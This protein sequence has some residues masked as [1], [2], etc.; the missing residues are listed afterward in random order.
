MMASSVIDWNAASE[1]GPVRVA[2]NTNISIA[3]PSAVIKSAVDS[4][5]AQRQFDVGSLPTLEE[6]LKS[7]PDRVSGDLGWEILK[8]LP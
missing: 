2:Q 6:H 1:E 8:D 4:L 5:V 7:P 3:V